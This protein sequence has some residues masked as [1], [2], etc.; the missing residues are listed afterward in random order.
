MIIE[1]KCH[2]TISQRLLFSD[3]KV[4]WNIFGN[5][6]FDFSRFPKPHE[7]TDALLWLRN[8][9]I[10]HQI[11]KDETESQDEKRTEEH[12]TL[13]DVTSFFPT[14]PNP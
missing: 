11:S 10:F 2:T 3:R 1:I 9:L 5:V 12:R 13:G 6:N 4:N 8:S 14:F 7:C